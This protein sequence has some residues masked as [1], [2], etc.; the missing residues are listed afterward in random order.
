L[1]DA[2]WELNGGLQHKTDLSGEL[3]NAWTLNQQGNFADA[4][5]Q[6]DDVLRDSKGNV[7]AYIGRYYARDQ[8]KKP[9]AN[10]D[11][12]LAIERMMIS[13]G[14]CEADKTHD[15]LVGSARF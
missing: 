1:H 14:R 15:G 7:S 8:Q 11:I 3:S 5:L 6:F 13:G 2:E 4:E 10:N 12:K 9:G